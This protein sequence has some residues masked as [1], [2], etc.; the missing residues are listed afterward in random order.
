MMRVKD[1]VESYAVN[2]AE[3]RDASPQFQQLSDSVSQAS[4]AIGSALGEISQILSAARAARDAI[5]AA[6]QAA[7]AIGV[8]SNAIIDNINAAQQADPSQSIITLSDHR[9]G[10]QQACNILTTIASSLNT[11]QALCGKLNNLAA[12]QFL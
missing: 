10:V 4:Q 6:S 2:E 1:I 11:A 8:D 3:I 12:R 5:S 7:H 9:S